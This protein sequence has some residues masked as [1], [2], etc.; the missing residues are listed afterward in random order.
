M[1]GQLTAKTS[2]IISLENLYVYSIYSLGS[3]H[4][5]PTHKNETQKLGIS[6]A[7]KLMIFGTPLVRDTYVVLTSLLS[8]RLGQSE[9][10]SSKNITQGAESLAF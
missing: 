8:E 9:S 2:K 3:S 4:R 10:S 5:L 7:E 1:D 6:A